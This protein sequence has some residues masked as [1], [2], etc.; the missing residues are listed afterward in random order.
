MKS[1]KTVITITK[2]FKALTIIATV[3]IF[4]GAG[5]CFLG[6]LIINIVKSEPD[7]IEAIQNII[8]ELI[9]T[10]DLSDIASANE[11][12]RVMLAMMV[13]SGVILIGNGVCMLLSAMLLNTAVKQGT[14]FCKPVVKTARTYGIAFIAITIVASITASI[15]GKVIANPYVL[16]LSAN[17]TFLAAGI[18]LIITSFFIDYGADLRAVADSVSAEPAPTEPATLNQPENGDINGDKENDLFD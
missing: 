9:K 10:Y 6:A 14:P 16:N 15:I 7:F 8:E 4:L 11:L 1:L 3:L 18:A 2:V 13:F 5:A 12:I 17:Y